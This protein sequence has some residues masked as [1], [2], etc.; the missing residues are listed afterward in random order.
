MCKELFSNGF[1]VPKLIT[2][3]LIRHTCF[4][5]NTR[6]EQHYFPYHCRRVY[7]DQAQLS[8]TAQEI[9]ETLPLEFWVRVK[10]GRYSATITDS[11][12]SLDYLQKNRIGIENCFTGRAHRN[13]FHYPMKVFYAEPHSVNN[14]YQRNTPL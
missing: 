1:Q 14:S 10:V 6:R 13:D 7:N 2:D 4:Y 5:G 3:V 8:K 12:T 9:I 11:P